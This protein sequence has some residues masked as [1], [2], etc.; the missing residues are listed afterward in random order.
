M[1]GSSDWVSL[2]CSGYSKNALFFS[3]LSFVLKKRKETLA[4]TA[5]VAAC[6][7]VKW[8]QNQAACADG[9][10]SRHR[11]DVFSVI[12]KP[13]GL[14]RIARAGVCLLVFSLGVQ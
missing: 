4:I 5:C 9:D 2:P 3:S 8:A 11:S 13:E 12:E 1:P 10:F 14:D 7:A 6:V